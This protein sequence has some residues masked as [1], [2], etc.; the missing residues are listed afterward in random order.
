MEI[1]TLLK[2]KNRTNDGFA[3][4]ITVKK[5]IKSN[6]SVINIEK[7]FLSDH[8][9]YLIASLKRENIYY[10]IQ[11]MSFKEETFKQIIKTYEIYN[12]TNL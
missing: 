10:C 6:I 11:S 5:L 7:R 4:R 8:A 1:Q 2:I 9:P 3:C 12:N